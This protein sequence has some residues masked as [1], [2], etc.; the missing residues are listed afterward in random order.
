MTKGKILGF[1][2]SRDIIVIDPKRME[3]I[4]T[5][6]YPNNKKAMQSFLGK[7]NLVVRLISRSV[8]VVKPMHNMIKRDVV[9]KWN[10]KSKEAF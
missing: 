6:T 8:E 5:I 3:D 7:K 9:F 1:V 4:T 10:H 2:I